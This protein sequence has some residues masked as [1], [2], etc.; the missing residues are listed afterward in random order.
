VLKFNDAKRRLKGY[1]DTR[2]G[3]KHTLKT[4]VIVGPEV[5]GENEI[6]FLFGTVYSQAEKEVIVP[7]ITDDRELQTKKETRLETLIAPFVIT[8]NPGLVLFNNSRE[9]AHLAKERMSEILFDSPDQISSRTY[10]IAR[11]EADVLSG[12][13]DGM[14]TFNF[15]E[16]QGNIRSGYFYGDDV[17]Q[18]SMYGECVGSPRNFIGIVVTTPEMRLKV[19]VSR[20]GSVTI[21]TDWNNHEDIQRIYDLVKMLN[22]YATNGP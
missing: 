19:R 5:I 17:N 3:K 15:K 10:D 14:W 20:T 11:I 2:Q 16:R 22:P 7:Y 13:L 9:P 6:R 4:M 18:D 21:Y 8:S 12:K 1:F